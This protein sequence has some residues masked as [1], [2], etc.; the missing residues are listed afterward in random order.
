M[1]NNNKKLY[2]HGDGLLSLIIAF[3]LEN[4]LVVALLAVI[5][6]AGGI[7]TA[8]FDWNIAGITRDPVP[9]DAIPDLGENQQIVYTEWDG[10]SPKDV[11]DQITYPLSSRLL[12]I[13]GVKTVRSQSMFGFSTIYVIFDDSVD[14]YFSRDRVQEKLNSLPAG[15]LPENVVPRL[16]P[17]ATPLGQVF[18]Y[19]LEGRDKNGQPAGGWDQQ[20]LRSIQ[21]WLIKYE[22]MGVPGVSE[23]ASV[24]GFVKEY[25]VEADPDA[26][27]EHGVTLAQ[28]QSAVRNSNLD[29]GARTMEI[30]KVEYIIR[31]LGNV[32][33]ISDI[34]QAVLKVSDNVPIRVKDVARVFLGPALRRGALDK[35]G[36]EAVGGVVV[37]QYGENPMEVI[38]NVKK[39]LSNI[40]A[41]LPEKEITVIDNNGQKKTAV[42]KVTVVPFYDR[43]GLIEE[44][45]GTL[46]SALSQQIMVTII[47]VLAMLLHLRSS[48]IISMTLPLAVL[49]CFILMKV[50]NVTANVVAL[51]GIAIAI[52]TIVDMGIVLTENIIKQLN[53]A[54]E[55]ESRLHSVYYATKEVASAVGAAVATTIVGFMPVIFLTGDQGKL[56]R[57]LAYTKTFALGAS[58]I[59]AIILIPTFANWLLHKDHDNEHHH[60][61]LYMRIGASVIACMV[62][63]WFLSQD[64]IP[65]GLGAGSIRN[66]LFCSVVIIVLIGAFYL[67]Y[68]L[69][70]TTLRWCLNH[71][72]LF[73]LLPATLTLAGLSI[74]RTLKPELMP[75]LDEGSFLYMPST[76]PHASI[77]EV[78]EVLSQQDKRL[79]SVPEVQMAVGKLGRADTPLD[80][81]PVD[82][83]ETVIN[84]YSEYYHDSNGRL[85]LFRYDPADTDYERNFTGQKVSA[86]DD[87]PYIVKG[88]YLRNSDGSLIASESGKPFRQWRRAL[89]PALNE[90][91]EKWDGIKSPD[92]IWAEIIR[93]TNIAGVTSASKLGPIETRIVMLQSGMK[94]DT[95]I[96]LIGRGNIDIRQLQEAGV[97]IQNALRTVPAVY[98]SS[99]SMDRIMGKPYLELEIDRDAISRHG[100]NISDVQ[101]IIQTAIG[102]NKVGRTIEGRERY[103]ILV[104]YMREL[105]DSPEALLHIMADTPYGAKIPL[106]QLLV[107]HQVRF[108]RGPK[109]I[110][111]E[112]GGLALYITFDTNPGYSSIEAVNDVRKIFTHM[113]EKGALK[114][115]AGI[116]YEFVGAYQKYQQTMKYLMLLVPC[117]L[118][119]IFFILYMQFKSTVTSLIVFSGV[120]AAWMGG[121]VMIWLYGQDWFMNFSVFDVSMRELFQM[122]EIRLSTAV[123]VGFLALFGIATD[124]GVVMATYLEQKYRQHAPESIIE[125]R[126]TTLKAALRRIRP[127][128][129]TTATTILALLPVLSSTGRGSEIMAPMA[130]P[131]F[132]GMVFELITMFIVPVVWCW[133][134]EIRIRK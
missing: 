67:F 51:A 116:T 46:E 121:F 63:L 24:G 105:R 40:A 64:W 53:A 84:Y 94:G 12:S 59:V 70:P 41:S 112:N 61:G 14:F 115:P 1:D 130:V 62:A 73:L 117:A 71:K 26:M 20:Q 32:Q 86:P 60:R 22:L 30:N 109:I 5:I 96:K 57:P 111:S 48:L 10:R 128:L 69:Y 126:D 129:M 58:L 72:L 74:W 34:E 2:S 49:L 65:L 131:I 27:R 95:G 108:E 92:D 76:M 91:R 123:W 107:N 18:W 97:E 127:C 75:R 132:G 80:P 28:L 134:Q 125:M 110:K 102:G 66:F 36:L 38:R 77:G 114:L 85:V 50:F 15:E 56:Y 29:V 7:Y 78:A 93:A 99:V 23:V 88:K 42:S 39:K 120:A 8:P 55:G 13:S 79:E 54:P 101:N 31:G 68:K 119:I 45:L 83:I 37:A 103:S 4:K 82:M 124:D 104:R 47:V 35:N 9:V 43:S 113:Q 90:G 25:Q 133:Y 17:D 87:K 100:L 16:G 122:H 11:E 33:K 106:S 52:G 81:A 21:D 6:I 98:P 118:L 19:T 44:T 89:D 3:L